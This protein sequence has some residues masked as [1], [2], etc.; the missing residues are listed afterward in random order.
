MTLSPFSTILVPIDKSENA[1]RAL[2]Y[3]LKLAKATTSKV[4]I[5]SVIEEIT[6]SAES[7][8]PTQDLE[9]LLQKST[10]KYIDDLLSNANKNYGI[11]AEGIVRQ[12]G[13]PAKIILDVAKSEGADLIVMGSRG[14]GSFKEM[15]LGSISHAVIAHSNVPVLIVR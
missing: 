14:M 5:L 8:V 11:K 7:Y 9:K 12:G 13:H 6:S 15:L 1:N 10:R 2:E 3:T 4:I